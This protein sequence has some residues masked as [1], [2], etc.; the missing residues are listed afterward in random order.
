[1]HSVTKRFVVFRQDEKSKDF[2]YTDD[3][4]DLCIFLGQSEAFCLSASMYPGLKPNS[5]Y[6]IGSGLGLQSSFWY[7][8]FL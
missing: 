2:C 4:G 1:M 8:Q 3:I 6:Y 7:G 5:I